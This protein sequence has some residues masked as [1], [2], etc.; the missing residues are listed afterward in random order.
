[1]VFIVESNHKIA[2]IPIARDYCS[3]PGKRPLP[4][5]RPCTAFQGATVAASIQVYGILIPGKR[6]CR[7]KSRVM[8]KRPWALTRDTTV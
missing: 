7:P 5:K 2:L 4:G 3:V 8:L 6:P 1:M